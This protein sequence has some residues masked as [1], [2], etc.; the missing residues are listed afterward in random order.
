MSRFFIPPASVDG[1]K[2]SISGKEAHHILDVMRLKVSDKVVTFDGTGKEYSGVIRDISRN[3]LTVEITET[4]TPAGK[5]TWKITLIQAMPKKDKMDYI[6][7]KSTELGVHSI[8]PVIT[9]RTIPDWD[10][11][12]K[13]S[14]AERWRKIAKEAA[15]QCGRL[16]IPAVSAISEFTDAISG[17]ADFD[18]QLIAILSEETITIKEAMAGF[19][20]GRIVIAI[21]PEGDFTADEARAAEGSGFRA[22]S[23]GPRVLKSD[24]AGLVLLSILN[25]ELS[26]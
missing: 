16:D 5:E 6:V 11:P 26:N 15:K 22:I 10:E 19:K 13:R 1:K 18:K 4:R 12:K 20:S 2:I 9:R 17:F 25:Y 21:G 23:L 8:V 7:E 14:Q 3:S 24:T